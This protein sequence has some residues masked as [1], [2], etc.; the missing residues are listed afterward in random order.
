MH[1]SDIIPCVRK[2]EIRA[3][4][5]KIL[6]LSRELETIRLHQ[7]PADM[8]R[9]EFCLTMEIEHSLQEGTFSFPAAEQTEKNKRILIRT[10]NYFSAKVHLQEEGL[11]FHCHDFVELLYVY[12]GH[13]RQYL[14]N[15]ECYMELQEGDLFLLNQNV[16]HG[17]S[18]DEKD[19]VLIKIIIP[20]S[21]LQ[22]VFIQKLD[23]KNA[24]YSFL[25][26]AREAGADRYHYIHMH[27]V[28]EMVQELMLQM[29]W[30]FYARDKAYEEAEKNYLQ[31]LFIMLT[32]EKGS[33][34]ECTH[35]VAKHAQ[36]IRQI[37][38]YLYEH[39]DTITLSELAHRYA[40]NPSYLSRMIRLN[41]GI[42]FQ[43][44]LCECRLDK[45]AELLLRSG[46]SVEKIAGLVGYDNPVPIYR[47]FQNKYHMSPSE[48]RKRC[49][50]PLN[51]KKVK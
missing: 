30:E 8:V 15:R 28:S 40:Y 14:E 7:K 23:H 35:P 9:E 27:C 26:E 5:E 44:L 10:Q 17:I 31:L 20:V 24:I 2:M 37:I 41:C 3:D 29:M 39:S 32:R 36:K 4:F 51:H 25:L 1:V 22:N 12:R 11:Y 6:K 21:F 18:Q 48:F 50:V 46:D 13:C 47:G 43:K 16:I 34:E 49:G 33:L 42:P 38:S 45:A 19:A